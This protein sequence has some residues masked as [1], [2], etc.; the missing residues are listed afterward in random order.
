MAESTGRRSFA[1]GHLPDQVR[2]NEVG[3]RSFTGGEGGVEGTGGQ[4]Q[5]TKVLQQVLPGSVAETRADLPDVTQS[6][7]SRDA[8]QERSEPAVSFAPALRPSADDD[9][10][11]AE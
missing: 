10:L 4:R 11:S 6:V 7:R 1:V 3:V 2:P 9:L 8:E 5:R